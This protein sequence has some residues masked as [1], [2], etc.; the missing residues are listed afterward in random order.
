ML[1]EISQSKKDRYC[2]ISI[3]GIWHS[4]IHR[5][6]SR[7]VIGG[8]WGVGEMGKCWLKDRKFPL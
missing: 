1:S 4:Q 2:V 3:C 5:H 7:M 8:D 6:R